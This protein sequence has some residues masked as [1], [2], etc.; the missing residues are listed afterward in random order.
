MVSFFPRLTRCKKDDRVVR[1]FNQ[2]VKPGICGLGCEKKI[3]VQWETTLS[4]TGVPC[5][6]SHVFDKNISCFG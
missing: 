2:E 6:F 5:D 3:K 4:L 1:E